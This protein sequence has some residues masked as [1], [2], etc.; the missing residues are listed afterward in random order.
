MGS[1]SIYVV[2]YRLLFEK[3]KPSLDLTDQEFELLKASLDV[4]LNQFISLNL[5]SAF[6]RVFTG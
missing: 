2:D 3:E 5:P 1:C 6:P 4:G